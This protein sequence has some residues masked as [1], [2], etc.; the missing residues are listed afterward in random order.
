MKTIDERIAA[1]DA[2]STALVFAL[3]NRFERK[4]SESIRLR[5]KK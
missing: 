2:V 3:L 5:G 1:L 4:A